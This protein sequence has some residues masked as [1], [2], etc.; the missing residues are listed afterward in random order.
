MLNR[1]IMHDTHFGVFVLFC[2]GFFSFHFSYLVRNG[3]L[4]VF[5]TVISFNLRYTSIL[6]NIIYVFFLHMLHNS[7]KMPNES[8]LPGDDYDKVQHIPAAP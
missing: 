8:D 5:L 6:L 4:T 2:F 7:L 1:H 3:T